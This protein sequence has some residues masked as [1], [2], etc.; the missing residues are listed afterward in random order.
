MDQQ[1]VLPDEQPAV[2]TPAQAN[3]AAA[4]VQEQATTTATPDIEAL[5]E[6]AVNK[7]FRGIQSMQDKQ[8]KRIEAAVT[9]QLETLRQAG[10]EATPAQAAKIAETLKAQMSAEPNEPEAAPAPAAAKPQQAAQAAAAGNVNDLAVKIMDGMGMRVT[11]SDPEAALLK[12]DGTRDEYVASIPAAV[13]AKQERI[14]KEKAGEPAARVPS[15]QA[16]AAGNANIMQMSSLE[17]LT[18][19]LKERK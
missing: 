15:G 10:I 5:V 8:A 17:R 7:A 13:K 12:L 9:R 18:L 6:K 19:A 2:S 4:P 14:A 16:A 1:I 11:K 3:E